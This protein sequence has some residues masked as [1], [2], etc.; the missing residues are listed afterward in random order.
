M[1]VFGMVDIAAITS[2]TTHRDARVPDIGLKLDL[3]YPLRVYVLLCK[4]ATYYVGIAPCSDIGDRVRKQFAG[5]GSHYCRI[6]VPREVLCIWPAADDCIEA[7]MYFAMQKRLFNCGSPNFAKLGG[8]VQTSTATSPLTNMQAEQTRRQLLGRCF[9]C[10]GPHSSKSPR[11]SGVDNNC[12]TYA[13]GNC[14][15][16]ITIASNGCSGPPQKRKASDTHVAVVAPS[17]SS[18]TSARSV[19]VPL[20]TAAQPKAKRQKKVVTWD[21]VKSNLQSA[22]TVSEH[23]GVP[24]IRL[25]DLYTAM[26]EQG[27][28]VCSQSP[29]QKLGRYKCS[30]GL[31]LNVDFCQKK[32][33]PGRGPAPYWITWAAA[34]KI[35][36]YETGR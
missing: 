9:T 22:Y 35:F 24:H 29:G 4:N 16:R 25:L 32:L 11:C 2:R 13:C 15:A 12:C 34:E 27:K 10:G 31:K 5:E 6:N 7:A 30:L 26:G 28:Q 33:S 21:V 20:S 17:Q 8:W 18:G 3:S 1:C 19:A 23:N 36:G 14:N